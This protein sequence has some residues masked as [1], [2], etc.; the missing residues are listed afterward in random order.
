MAA[1]GDA[2]SSAAMTIE[3]TGPS[4]RI[5]PADITAAAQ[6]LGCLREAVQAVI[7][8]ETGGAGGYLNDGS[9]RPRILFEAKHFGDATCHE[10]DE[11]NPGI[12]CGVQNWKLYRGGAAEYTRL[13][14]AIVLNEAAALASTSWGLFQV[15][16]SNSHSLGY[17][18]VEAFVTLMVASEANQLDAFVRYCRINNLTEALAGLEW[19]EFARGYNGP[20]YA[21]N[22]YD[23]KLADAFARAGGVLRNPGIL[24]LGS[25]GADVRAVQLRLIN[26]G[27]RCGQVDG[28]YGR[29]TEF[30]L[31][32]F[33]SMMGLS[34]DGIAGPDTLNLLSVR[35]MPA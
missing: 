5:C 26:Y 6:K 29:S 1:F 24:R 4:V 32:R 19:A 27:F 33:Q 17:D 10:F 22:G 9:G 28:I 11:S 34:V 35:S 25:R 7:T 13:D 2:C 12:S 15:L 23:T 31:R 16:G 14:E 8:V 20:A 3:L 18:S 30:A 21:A